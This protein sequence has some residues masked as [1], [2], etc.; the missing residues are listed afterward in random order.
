MRL[1][2]RCGGE[3]SHEIAKAWLP[4]GA[5]FGELAQAYTSHDGGLE[6]ADDSDVHDRGSGNYGQVNSM[7]VMRS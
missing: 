7:S 2:R 3:W 4:V 1:I 5:T 6:V